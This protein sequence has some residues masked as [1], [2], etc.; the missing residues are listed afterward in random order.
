MDHLTEFTLLSRPLRDSRSAAGAASDRVNVKRKDQQRAFARF[1]LRSD[2]VCAELARMVEVEVLRLAQGKVKGREGAATQRYDL[3]G[4]IEEPR[5]GCCG[6]GGWLGGGGGSLGAE[7]ALDLEREI[8]VHHRLDGGHHQIEGAAHGVAALRH[9]LL[10]DLLEIGA[11]TRRGVERRGTGQ[12]LDGRA[13]VIHDPLLGAHHEA[14]A[15]G[16]L[17][18]CIHGKIVS[19]A[20]IA[21][22]VALVA[23]RLHD[24]RHTHG[25]AHRHPQRQV[26][27][28]LGCQLPLAARV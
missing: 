20:P 4:Q 21:V 6:G 17:G 12:R 27:I 1:A 22:D 3:R 9:E 10:T 7:G 24:P 18:Q 28:I 15:S 25:H 13:H 11:Q 26:R 8:G 5:G 16:S 14:E 23:K 2:E 19:H